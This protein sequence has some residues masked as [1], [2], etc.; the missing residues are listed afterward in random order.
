MFELVCRCY[1]NGYFDI[2]VGFEGLK[3]A[4]AEFVEAP[5]WVWVQSTC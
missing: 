4:S 2:R 1:R 3:L 5:L